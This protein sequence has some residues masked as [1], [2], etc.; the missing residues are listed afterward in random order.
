M[1][2]QVSSGRTKKE[3]KQKPSTTKPDSDVQLDDLELL[4][5]Q[6][7]Q[8]RT[9]RASARADTA[10]A[11]GWAPPRIGTANK[12]FLIATVAAADRSKR[13]QPPQTSGSTPSSQYH[14]SKGSYQPCDKSYKRDSDQRRRDVYERAADERTRTVRHGDGRRVEDHQHRRSYKHGQHRPSDDED[15]QHRRGDGRA[16]NR[17]EDPKLKD[18]RRDRDYADERTS[19]H[20]EGKT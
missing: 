2:R 14:S 9:K 8:A 20:R 5:I 17:R 13:T 19:S 16:F 1:S 18:R 15:S 4:A 6:R 10:G 3:K 7:L 11:A 12:R